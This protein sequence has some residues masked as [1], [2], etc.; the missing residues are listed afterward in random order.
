[1]NGKKD[2]AQAYRNE[3]EAGLAIRDSGLARDDIFITTKYSGLNGLDIEDS[4]QNSLKNVCLFF[5]QR[6][7][8]LIH[9][10]ISG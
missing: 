3:A 6:M 5:L 9:F 2:T 4:I 1:L 8:L 7:I 10:K